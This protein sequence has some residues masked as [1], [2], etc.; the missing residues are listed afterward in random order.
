MP[1]SRPKKGWTV[2][3]RR[4]FTAL[5]AT[6]AAA[7]ATLVTAMAAPAAQAFTL[8]QAHAGCSATSLDKQWQLGPAV[9]PNAGPVGLQLS[10]Y[11][12][13]AGLTPSQF[14]SRYWNSHGHGSWKYPPDNGFLV[15]GGQPVEHSLT[16]KPGAPLD[17]YG[18]TAGGFLAPAGTP[19]WARSLPP[20]N[21]ADAPGFN[22]NYHTYTVVKAFKVEAGPAAP[23][24]GQPG[25]GLQYQ[26]VPSLLPGQA[27]PS[28]AWLLAQHYLAATN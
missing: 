25:L 19:Y 5:A 14:L 17:R 15:A 22:C 2:P 16:L 7:I 20:S 13:L 18:S 28:V 23:A 6:A 21:L 9:T 11:W 1:F 10:G 12:R 27:T 8:P 24:F 4:S 3:S 26:L